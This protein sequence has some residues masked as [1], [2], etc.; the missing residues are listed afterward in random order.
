HGPGTVWSGGGGEDLDLDVPGQC[1]QRGLGVGRQRRLAVRDRDD[2]IDQVA[3]LVAG[4]NAEEAHTVVAGALDDGGPHLLDAVRRGGLA[5]DERIEP[6]DAD[7]IRQRGH[8]LDELLVL[9]TE[10]C[11]HELLRE[12]HQLHGAGNALEFFTNGVFVAGLENGHASLYS[13]RHTVAVQECP[14]MKPFVINRY[15]RMVFPSNFF[16]NLDFSVFETLDQFA[17]VI[18]RDFEEKA[19]TETDI[20]TRLESGAY[21]G[22]YELLRD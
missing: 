21:R 1:G 7:L 9:T 11:R 6:L 18:R 10:V 4:G 16:P 14:R 3:E 20:V 12:H 19:P 13:R 15:G 22:R 17:A 5:V 2:R 8:L